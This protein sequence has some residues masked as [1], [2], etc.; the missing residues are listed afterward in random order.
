M[1]L[2]ATVEV[3]NFVRVRD[4]I[5]LLRQPQRAYAVSPRFARALLP[6]RGREIY[7]PWRPRPSE[8]GML[9]TAGRRDGWGAPQAHRVVVFATWLDD[10]PRHAHLERSTVTERWLGVFEPVHSHG[11]LDGADPL[12]PAA[13]GTWQERRGSIFT[14]GRAGGSFVD[15]VHQNNRVV[16]E[17]R[18][19]P[20]LLTSFNL[21]DLE[22]GFGVSTFSCWDD[23]DM[24]MNFAYRASPQHREA[25]RRHREG[26]YGKEL[27]FA[28]LALLDSEGTICGR[29]PFSQACSDV[30]PD[31]AIVGNHGRGRGAGR[32]VRARG[33]DHEPEQSLLCRTG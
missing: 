2:I 27:Y 29:N 31:H 17:L 4:A 16:E 3:V 20:S 32:V 25:I 9:A 13:R 21:L 18:R 12:G 8:A 26:R 24:A 10:E 15:F 30:E 23:L 6:G 19:M 33:A 22:G 5:R 11:T 1:A 14:Y 28:R 7:P